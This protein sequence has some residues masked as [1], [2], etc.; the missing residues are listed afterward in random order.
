MAGL[1]V[2]T[3]WTATAAGLTATAAGV[4]ATA[5]ALLPAPARTPMGA[6]RARTVLQQGYQ[7][8]YAQQGYAQ[9]GGYTGY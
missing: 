7:Q 4:T 9:Q 6:V 1:T 3:A 2:L 8:G 5:A